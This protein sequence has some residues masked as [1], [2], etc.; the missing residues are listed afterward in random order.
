MAVQTGLRSFHRIHGQLSALAFFRAKQ[1]IG[2]E[3]DLLVDEEV[4][5]KQLVFP[6]RLIAY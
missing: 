2:S 3:K 5:H 6:L 1:G 4:N